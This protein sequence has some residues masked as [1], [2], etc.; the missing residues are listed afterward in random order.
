MK[1][2]L[3]SHLQ[4][5]KEFAVIYLFSVT[6]VY[7]SHLVFFPKFPFL[8]LFLLS[9]SIAANKEGVRFSVSGDLG[10]GNIQ[11]LPTTNVDAKPEETVKIVLK[12]KVEL[13]FALKYLNSFSKATPL[14]PTVT[15]MMSNSV[16]LVV[17][18]KIENVGHLR[19]Y[20][21]P[22]IDDDAEGQ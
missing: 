21:A 20:L 15:L 11:L 13:T 17:E 16:P 12:E 19:F 14:S 6:Q 4:S 8:I 5:F 7:L 18:Y 9:V 10:N 22:K 3:Q 2:K 1:Q